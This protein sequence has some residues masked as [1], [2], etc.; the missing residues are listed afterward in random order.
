MPPP[1]AS[2]E[3]AAVA[4]C[5][6][7][8]AGVSKTYRSRRGDLLALDRVD[9]TVA[10]GEFIALVGPSGCGKS[11]LLRCIAGLEEPT[12]GRVAMTGP[13][14]AETAGGIGMVFQR[15][16]LLDWR[17]VLDNVLL[18]VELRGDDRRR[19]RDRA[20]ALLDRCGLADFEKRFP[21]ELSG[22][23][24]QR[25]AICRALVTE[26]RLLLFDEPFSAL[27]AFTRDDL[28]VELQA[29]SVEQGA[30]VVFVTHSIPEAV[31]LADRV[32]V[33]SPHPGRVVATVPVEPARPRDLAIRE[34]AGFVETAASIRA[35][36]ERVGVMRAGR[37]RPPQP[38]DTP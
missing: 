10:P 34:T 8:I 25:V 18:P 4:G 31:F 14:G 38:G 9:V 29:L 28:S 16:V 20:R 30:T 33:M 26:P 27:D 21:W 32:V 2:T 36:F 3:A 23:M 17:S 1:P 24:R 37:T 6:L 12:T 13:D 7:R 11:T 22:G 5:G 19:Y 35:I 15:D